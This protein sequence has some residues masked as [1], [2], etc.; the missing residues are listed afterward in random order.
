MGREYET[1]RGETYNRGGDKCFLDEPL[2]SQF[3]IYVIHINVNEHGTLSYF[4]FIY[5]VACI[6]LYISNQLRDE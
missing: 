5:S 3:R 6:T 2:I 4:T 1:G